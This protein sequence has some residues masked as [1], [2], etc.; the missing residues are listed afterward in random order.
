MHPRL[1]STFLL[2]LVQ[3]QWR[4]LSSGGLVDTAR[5]TGTRTQTST[6]IMPIAVCCG[7]TLAGW[8]SNRGAN[9]V[10][11]MSLISAKTRLSGGSTVG[12]SGSSSLWALV[13]QPPSLVYFGVI[14]GVDISMPELPDFSSS[15]TPHSALTLW[16]TGS[17]MRRLTTS[18][19]PV[20]TLSLQWLHWARAITTFTTNSP[21]ILGTPSGGTSTT[22]PNGSSLFVVGWALPRI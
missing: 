19:L 20:I 9:Q 1:Y 6:R 8:S 22:P 12:M 13:F 3:V 10:S 11:R 17:V 16:R 21:R 2:L 4:G 5:T 18:T 15:I 14:G 7:L